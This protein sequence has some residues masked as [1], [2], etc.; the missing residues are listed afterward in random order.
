M[1]QPKKNNDA[2]VR[3]LGKAELAQYLSVS[4][5]TIDNLVRAGKLPKPIAF[6]PRLVRW[7]RSEIDKVM[8][9]APRTERMHDEEKTIGDDPF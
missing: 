3:Y 1:T 6:S 2:L 9:R 7:D 5:S 4:R 8:A